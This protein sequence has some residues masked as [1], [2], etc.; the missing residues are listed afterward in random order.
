MHKNQSFRLSVIF[1]LLASILIFLDTVLFSLLGNSLPTTTIGLISTGIF[2]LSALLIAVSIFLYLTYAQ[3]AA[4][5]RGF[6]IA[7]GIV[8]VLSFFTNIVTSYLYSPDNFVIYRILYDSIRSIFSIWTAL[9]LLVVQ[10]TMA[11]QKSIASRGL[12]IAVSAVYILMRAVNI[13]SQALNAFIIDSKQFSSAYIT[14]SNGLMVLSQLLFS[15]SLI[16]T[17]VACIWSLWK[18]GALQA[19]FAPMPGLAGQ[20]GVCPHCGRPNGPD[21]N[22]CAVCA[23]PLK[24]L[25]PPAPQSVPETVLR[26][27]SCGAPVPPDDLYCAL[28]GEKTIPVK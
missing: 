9:I 26:C 19:A 8:L 3:K 4:R 7:A 22:F 21:A 1:C 20:P 15:L 12:G 27:T 2:Y 17:A 11:C 24:P 13:A 6:A 5:G 10:Y 18:G 28:C 23:I 14:A 16:L 25:A